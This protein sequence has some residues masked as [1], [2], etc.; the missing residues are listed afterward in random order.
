[1]IYKGWTIQN[2]PSAPVTGRW[3]AYRYGVRIGASTLDMLKS[4]DN[5]DR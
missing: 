5:R 3:K 2:E 1:M 4:I